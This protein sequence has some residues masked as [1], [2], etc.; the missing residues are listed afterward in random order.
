MFLEVD[1]KQAQKEMIGCQVAMS[2]IVVIQR[3]EMYV[4]Q[5]FSAGMVA[6]AAGATM[7]IE[8][9]DTNQLIQI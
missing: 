5:Q 3:L 4:D 1:D 6:Q 2:S 7:T 8:V 9:S